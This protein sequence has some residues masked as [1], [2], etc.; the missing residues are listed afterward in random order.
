MQ[1][2]KVFTLLLTVII[3]VT[4]CS[5]VDKLKEKLSSG[6]EDKKEETK[7][8]ETKEVT[9]GADLQFYNK[10]IEVSNKIQ[11]AG[12]KVYK[13][14][15]SDIPSAGS[16]TKNTFLIA[17]TFKFSVDNLERI[18]KEYNRSYFDGGELSKLNAS[19]EMK[20]EIEGEFKTL[21][22]T[23]EDYHAV[24][25]KVAE[26]Y[27]KGEYKEDL[28]KAA[29]YE[30]D[31]KAA[32]E[33]YKSAFDK[34]SAAIK[35]YKPQREKRDP[36]SVSNPDE[37]AVI[38]L[39][40]SYENTLDKAEEFY[41]AFNGVQYNGELT[42]AKDKFREFESSFKEDK[43]SVL[44]AEFTDK[45]KYMKYSYEDYFVKM[46]NMFLD[47]GTKFFDKAPSAKDEREF[48][49]MYDDVVNNYN[50]MITAYNSNINIVNTF[51]VY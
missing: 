37:R 31:M 9:K 13:D 3:A 40:N 38:V 19:G 15:A 41:E 1:K 51:K 35:K 45:T 10:Y 32:N 22:K 7:K 11:D 49:R 26:Y 5:F 46:T 18:M 50:Y 23:L 17:V 42:K 47:A 6:K 21:M 34:F 24:S 44:S 39:M 36:N 8:E 25:K 28:S 29:G 4:S 48:N 12:D 14:Y 43:N 2:L 33:K 16:I 30:E 20:S 27:S